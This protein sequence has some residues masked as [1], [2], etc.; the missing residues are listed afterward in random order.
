[1]VAVVA[2]IGKVRSVID[3]QVTAEDGYIGSPIPGGKVDFRTAK[4]A[5]NGHAVFHHK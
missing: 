4:A 3:S 2:I 5:I 1:M